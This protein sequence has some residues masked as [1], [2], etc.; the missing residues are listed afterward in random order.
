MIIL[1][2]NMLYLAILLLTIDCIV[3][4]TMAQTYRIL[5]R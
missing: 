1:L 4:V 3:L 5:F 2:Y